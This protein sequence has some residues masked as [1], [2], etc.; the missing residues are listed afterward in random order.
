[1]RLAGDSVLIRREF[2]EDLMS[3]LG[4]IA[5]LIVAA[6]GIWLLPATLQAKETESTQKA[7]AMPLWEAATLG[8][9][10]GMTEYLPVSSTGHLKLFQ[11][12]MGQ[13]EEEKKAADAF[14]ICIQIGA[15][16]AVVVLYF[17]RLKQIVRGILGSDPEGR[18]LF[19]HLI[20]AFLPAAVIGLTFLKSIKKDLM[21]VK[22]ITIAI[23][24]GALFILAMPRPQKLE[25]GSEAGKDLS[26]LRWWESLAIGIFQCLALWPGFSRSLATIL[27]CRVVG[28]KMSAAVEFSFLLGLITLSAATAKEAVSD[29][30]EIIAHYGVTSPIVALIVG[31]V[32][33]VI[34]VKFMISILNSYGL[35]PFAW[36]RLLLAAA[37]L[38]MW[39]SAS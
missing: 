14:A 28:L 35:T 13:S 24:T 27:G 12:W 19:V 33:A 32:S 6:L 7:D 25:D 34:S 20:I 29:G 3:D 16:L 15:I 2:G 17:Q 36:Y 22:P 21:D 10:E 5:I 30:S 23:F 31:F 38:T 11:L 26:A 37:C 1:L 8:L 4:R 39:R 18:K 9:I